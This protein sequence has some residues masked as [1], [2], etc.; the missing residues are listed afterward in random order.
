MCEDI[1]ERPPIP[2]K[3]SKQKLSFAADMRDAICERPPI[4]FQYSKQKDIPLLQICG[5]TFV[6][7][8]LATHVGACKA[9]SKTRPVFDVAMARIAGTEAA[10]LVNNGR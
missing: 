8:R 9:A 4:P 5:R 3:F 6:S 1:C 10:E 7:D 2:F